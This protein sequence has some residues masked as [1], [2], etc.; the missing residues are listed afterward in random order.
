M[1]SEE[2]Q[3][4][5]NEDLLSLAR[6]PVATVK[7]DAI[8]LLV[9]RGSPHAGHPDIVEEAARII[10]LEPIILKKSDPASAVAAN[11]L[12]GLLDVIASEV[13]KVRTLE[14][15]AG[16]FA[17]KHAVHE[18]DLLD[19]RLLLHRKHADMLE[20]HNS[21]S[22]ELMKTDSILSDENRSAHNKIQAAETRLALL[23]RSLWRKFVDWLKKVFRARST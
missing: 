2:L 19:L 23:E 4:L 16:Q 12:P 11:K 3:L 21:V 6:N 13:K 20:L 9:E 17:E 7:H 8:R 22:K 1:T 10:Y 18:T 14:F 15:R 5:R